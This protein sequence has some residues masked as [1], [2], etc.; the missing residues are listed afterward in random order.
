M[1]FELTYLLCCS[2]NDDAIIFSFPGQM[3]TLKL[4]RKEA[5]LF[6]KD[7]WL[8]RQNCLKTKKKKKNQGCQALKNILTYPIVK[9][10]FRL[11]QRLS[12]RKLYKNQATANIILDP[13]CH[14]L[15]IIKPLKIMVNNDT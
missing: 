15:N 14:H 7:F 5:S 9:T 3:K 11:L 4:G 12:R 1:K 10:A 2:K 6:I 13:M 8:L